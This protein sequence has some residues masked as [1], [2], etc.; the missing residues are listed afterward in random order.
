MN[1]PLK[2]ALFD[3][4]HRPPNA[5]STALSGACALL[6]AG[7]LVACDSSAQANLKVERLPEV[8]PSLPPVPKLPPPPHPTTYPDGSYSVYGVRKRI[9][10][11]MDTEL[12][13]TGFIVEV[14]MPPECEEEPC[15]RPAAPHMW[16]AD[17]AGET[18][19]TKRLMVAGYAENQDQIDEAIEK[20]KRGKVEAPPAESGILP[21]PTDFVAGN[22][23]TVSG[24]FT[25][26]SGSGFNSSE[27]LLE[28]RGHKTLSSAE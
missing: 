10:N 20:A 9:R 23:A 19:A 18:D 2:K 15:D 12:Q 1:S 16:I 25:R 17:T 6:L 3:R 13:V 27:G 24:R 7:A 21:I 4:F 28:Y 11:T 26:M 8:E 22:K 5:V 14:Y